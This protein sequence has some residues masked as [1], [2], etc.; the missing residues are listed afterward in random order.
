MSYF[1]TVEG[2]LFSLYFALF[3]FIT[4]RSIKDL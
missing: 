4:Y 3:W 1:I 2:V